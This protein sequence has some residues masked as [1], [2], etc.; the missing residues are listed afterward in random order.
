MTGERETHTDRERETQRERRRER[1]R[2]KR[3]AKECLAGEGAIVPPTPPPSPV[4]SY[5]GVS[6]AAP[7]PSC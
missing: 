1:E 2:Q 3:R 4:D 7:G 6:L 5:Q